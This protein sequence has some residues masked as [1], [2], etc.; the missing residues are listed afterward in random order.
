MKGVG[1]R[2]QGV[3]CR[4]QGVQGGGVGPVE[5]FGVQSIGLQ[6]ASIRSTQVQG[7]G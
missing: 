4:V 7:V 5:L 2:V 3:G 6:L 1:C